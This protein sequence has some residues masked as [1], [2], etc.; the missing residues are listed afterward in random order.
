MKEIW[1]HTGGSDRPLSAIGADG[2]CIQKFRAAEATFLLKARRI[3]NCTMWEKSVIALLPL[4]SFA[5]LIL[6]AP[7]NCLAVSNVMRASREGK[8]LYRSPFKGPE[9]RGRALL[10][11]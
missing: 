2:I 6:F 7:R 4:A 9:K 3:I 10:C 8:R 5:V 1:A 11:A